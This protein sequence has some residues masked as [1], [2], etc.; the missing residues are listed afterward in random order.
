[1]PNDDLWILWSLMLVFALISISAI[2]AGTNLVGLRNRQLDFIANYQ[3]S[4][5][6]DEISAPFGN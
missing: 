1:M 2:I 5:G 6:V 4:D 3:F